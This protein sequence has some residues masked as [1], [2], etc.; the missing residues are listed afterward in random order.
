MKEFGV[1]YTRRYDR[2]KQEY[3]CA[4]DYPEDGGLGGNID[5]E[6]EGIAL[7]VDDGDDLNGGY[8]V[9]SCQGKDYFNI[10]S[11]NLLTFIGSFRIFFGDHQVRDTDGVAIGSG[12]FGDKYP[13]GIIIVMDDGNNYKRNFKFASFGDILHGINECNNIADAKYEL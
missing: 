10:Y 9:L 4:Y 2:R 1:N 13:D 3:V 11:R 6:A 7:Y 12:N 8:Y 5:A